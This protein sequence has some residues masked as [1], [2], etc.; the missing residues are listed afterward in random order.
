MANRKPLSRFWIGACVGVA[1][2]GVVV[3]FG[4]AMMGEQYDTVV[5]ATPPWDEPQVCYI[6]MIPKGVAGSECVEEGPPDSSDESVSDVLTRDA[7]YTGSMTLAG[8]TVFGSS[9]LLMSSRREKI[10]K[11]DVLLVAVGTFLLAAT[12]I[13]FAISMCCF[14]PN[15]LIQLIGV[16]SA[17]FAGMAVVGYAGALKRLTSTGKPE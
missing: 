15:D 13:L 11:W 5:L 12:H 16:A 3:M 2:G 4:D 8:V 14:T 10:S 6:A 1:I 7:I 9:A 17:I